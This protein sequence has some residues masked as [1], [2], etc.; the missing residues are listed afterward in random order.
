MSWLY[1]ASGAIAAAVF[2]YLAAALFY[3][4]KF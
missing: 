1:I 2:I 4:E 3:P